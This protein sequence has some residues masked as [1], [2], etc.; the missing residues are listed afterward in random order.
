MIVACFITPIIV[1]FIGY[2]LDGRFHW[3][4][5]ST[6]APTTAP[7]AAPHGRADRRAKL[8]GGGKQ[9]RLCVKAPNFHE[10]SLMKMMKLEGRI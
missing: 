10:G 7:T 2:W 5:E 9:T 4:P 1:F 3:G 6:A 8:S